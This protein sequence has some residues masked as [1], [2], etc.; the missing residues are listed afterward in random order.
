MSPLS[1]TQ[2]QHYNAPNAASRIKPSFIIVSFEIPFITRFI[3]RLNLPPIGQFT[4]RIVRFTLSIFVI[5]T[6]DASLSRIPLLPRTL[7]SHSARRGQESKTSAVQ[8]LKS[9]VRLIDA[10]AKK[11]PDLHGAPRRNATRKTRA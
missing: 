2:N 8:N 3:A 9:L 10:L 6:C 4:H 7:I 11:R 5:S 1:R